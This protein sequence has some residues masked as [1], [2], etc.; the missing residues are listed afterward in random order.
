MGRW[1]EGEGG[2]CRYLRKYAGLCPNIPE[3]TEVELNLL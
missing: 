1:Q 2:G 3:K